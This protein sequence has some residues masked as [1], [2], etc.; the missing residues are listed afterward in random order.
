M[1]PPKNRIVPAH[2]SRNNFVP[3]RLAPPG[4]GFVTGYYEPEID[5]SR[6]AVEPFTVPL[7]RRP[8][9]LVRITKD[10]RPAPFDEKLEAARQTEK[11][12]VPYYDRSEIDA[13]ILNDRGLELVF[14]E[15]PVDAFFIHVQGSARIR[16]R[17]GSAIRVSYDG[18]NGH[19]YTSI[20][21]V[22]IER[23]ALDRDTMSMDRLRNWL[24][25]HPEEASGVMAT[26]RSFIFFREVSGLAPEL[27]PVGAAGV[28]LTAGRS[29]AVDKVQHTYGSP[30]W[31]DADLPLSESAREK[32][33]RRLMIAQ[34]TGSAIIGSARGD[35]FIGSGAKAGSIAGRV[36]HSA[37]M[38]VFVP[39]T[40]L[41]GRDAD[42][43]R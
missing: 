34:D 2:S 19:P 24:N 1:R 43:V 15:S 21:R 32:P 5:G 33:F 9:D 7:Y 13:G 16:L 4:D 22:L 35:V 27:G 38:V 36:R 31:V 6:Q 42:G 39:R 40:Q 25:A 20:G 14:I 11:G 3:F 41:M 12:L 23:G 30:V 28:Q 26:N 18:K 8:D 17:D 10:N 29:I 37:D